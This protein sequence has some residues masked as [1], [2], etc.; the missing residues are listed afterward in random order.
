MR[1]T[2]SV[3]A[4]LTTVALA[5]P[6]TAAEQLWL[7]SDHS[8]YYNGQTTT[9]SFSFSTGGV[10]V[11]ASAWSIQSNN[12]IED[13]TLGIW[14]PGLG[15][16]SGTPDRRGNYSDQHVI[17][18]NG[19]DEFIL[20]AFDQA[21]N[22][23]QVLLNTGYDSLRDTDLTVGFTTTALPLSGLDGKSVSYLSNTLGMSLYDVNGGSS[24][25]WRSI[26]SGSNVGNLWLIGA[27]FGDSNDGF[28]LESLK[29]TSVP[30]V[31][32]PSTWLM[33]ILGFGLVGGVMRSKRRENL[34]VSYS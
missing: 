30:A 23:S 16:Y 7:D 11:K 3:I 2:L 9:G 13:E 20:L 8:S 1:K 22:I 5:T 31:P 19:V 28:K 4:A 17:D 12:K 10:T 14:S 27:K 15:I 34:T 24:S 26:N 6:A 25:G 18:N 32:E 21:V 29:F 33:M